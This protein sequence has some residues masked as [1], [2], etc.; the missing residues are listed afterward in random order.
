MGF[1]S[2][3]RGKY[4]DVSGILGSRCWASFAVEK[5]LP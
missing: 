5:N 3:G 2:L 1:F 4:R